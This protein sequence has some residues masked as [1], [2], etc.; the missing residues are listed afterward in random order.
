M[1]QVSSV[2]ISSKALF[3]V[4]KCVNL[5]IKAD[6]GFAVCKRREASFCIQQTVHVL[7]I[8]FGKNTKIILYP[9]YKLLKK[10]KK[11]HPHGMSVSASH[12]CLITVLDSVNLNTWMCFSEEKN[13][14]SC[15]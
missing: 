8:I 4:C 6:V 9:L 1:Q 15:S 7:S 14:P 12:T 11:A 2:H 3:L 13:F 10:K 5:S